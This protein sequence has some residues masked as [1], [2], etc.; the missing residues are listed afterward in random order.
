VADNLSDALGEL[1]DADGVVNERTW[2]DEAPRK[3]GGAIG[4]TYPYVVIHDAIALA[5]ALKGDT[6]AIR[7]DRT[8]QASLWERLDKEDPDVAARLIRAID[9]KRVVLDN[10]HRVRFSVESAA[11]LAEPDANVVQRAV[12]IGARHDPAV[13]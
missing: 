7:L 4:A 6:R 1:I 8:M 9:G 13:S 3:A 11:R 10:G 2:A 12:T 5:P